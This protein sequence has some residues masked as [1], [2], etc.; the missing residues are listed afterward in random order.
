MHLFGDSAES[1]LNDFLVL[2]I[3]TMKISP[4]EFLWFTTK[5]FNGMLKNMLQIIAIWSPFVH[6]LVWFTLISKW[7]ELTDKVHLTQFYLTFR[8]LSLLLSTFQMEEV[9]MKIAKNFYVSFHVKNQLQWQNCIIFPGLVSCVSKLKLFSLVTQILW[10][11]LSLVVVVSMGN[12]FQSSVYVVTH[13][14]VSS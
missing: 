1:L 13:P 9:V 4:V 14:W 7:T 2:N 11:P 10:L 3:T 5:R 6:P 12:R 8:A